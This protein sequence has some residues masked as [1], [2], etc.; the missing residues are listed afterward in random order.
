MKKKQAV[1]G[2]KNSGSQVLQIGTQAACGKPLFPGQNNGK[3][4]TC[5]KQ[6]V[7]RQFNGRHTAQTGKNTQGTPDEGSQV[8]INIAASLPH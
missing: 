5:H 2:K 1:D 4:N 7:K 6:P 3:D 8:N